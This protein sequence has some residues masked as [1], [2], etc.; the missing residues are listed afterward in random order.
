MRARRAEN[1][2]PNTGNAYVGTVVALGNC[3]VEHDLPTEVARES[4]RRSAMDRPARLQWMCS[5]SRTTM[6]WATA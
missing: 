5:G 1:L 4:A 6:R 3:F 2:G